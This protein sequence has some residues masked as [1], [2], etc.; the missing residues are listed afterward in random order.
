[1]W[2]RDFTWLP[3]RFIR[4]VHEG[5]ADYHDYFTGRWS[6]RMRD[7]R[8]WIMGI[9]LLSFLATPILSRILGGIPKAGPSSIIF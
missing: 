8:M 5:L 3:A 4:S 6:A 9:G 2:E 7:H 1:M